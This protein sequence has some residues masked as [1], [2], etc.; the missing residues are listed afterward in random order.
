[1][2]NFVKI[3]P[4]SEDWEAW[5]LN[6]KLIAEGHTVKASDLLDAVADIF[7]NNIEYVQIPDEIAEQGFD[8]NLEDMLR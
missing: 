4:E 7:P 1:M 6:G 8:D 5:Y 2:N 3:I